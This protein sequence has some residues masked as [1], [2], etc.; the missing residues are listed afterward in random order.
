[1]WK[2]KY[3]K[4]EFVNFDVNGERHFGQIVSGGVYTVDCDFKIYYSVEDMKDGSMLGIAEEAIEKASSKEIND[5]LI[6]AFKDV[7]TMDFSSFG[8]MNGRG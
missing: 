7:M 8:G 6:D 5:R 1:M 4:G 2:Y 3:K